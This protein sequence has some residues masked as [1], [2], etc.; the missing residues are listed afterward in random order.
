MAKKVY[1]EITEKIRDVYFENEMFEGDIQT[2]IDNL[3]DIK[4]EAVALGYSDIKIEEECIDYYDKSW[5]LTGT[6]NETDKERNK[7]L[8]KAQK[9]KEKKAEAKRVK[10]EKDL[11]EYERLKKKYGE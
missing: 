6:R 11:A 7:R 3:S 5:F 10:D 1:K 4:K 2:I 9:E 8:K